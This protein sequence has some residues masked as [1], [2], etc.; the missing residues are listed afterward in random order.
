[1]ILCL[2]HVFVGKFIT[3]FNFKLIFE[4]RF[5]SVIIM[6]AWSNSKASLYKIGLSMICIKHQ[7]PFINL[8][9]EDND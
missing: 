4:I 7:A 9:E 5:T 8:V 2:Y 3:L 6:C 1:M